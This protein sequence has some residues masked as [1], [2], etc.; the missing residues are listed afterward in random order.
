MSNNA[1]LNGNYASLVSAIRAAYPGIR[2]TYAGISTEI[3]GCTASFWSNFDYASTDPYGPAT[4]DTVNTV[5]V[6]TAQNAWSN[7]TWP[8][9]PSNQNTFH[10]NFFNTFGKLIHLN[11][12]GIFNTVGAA[13]QPGVGNPTG[14]GRDDLEQA[15]YIQGT[16]Q[17]I[18]GQPWLGGVWYWDQPAYLH[19]ATSWIGPLDWNV[20][21]KSGATVITNKF[22]N[23][24]SYEENY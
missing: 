16:L 19:P 10:Q 17:A 22:H 15:N 21:D 14:G 1:A 18:H 3:A 5:S 4:T 24:V 2:V 20:A 23:V 13:S 12:F 6:A 11:E 9:W 7:V 8:G